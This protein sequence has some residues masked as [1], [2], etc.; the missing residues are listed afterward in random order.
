MPRKSKIEAT[1]RAY[2]V[3]RRRDGLSHEAIAAELVQRGTPL[4]V[5]TVHKIAPGAPGQ[6]PTKS[7]KARAS[8][9]GRA[10]PA[11]AP[12]STPAVELPPDDADV[13]TL[14]GWIASTQKLA[15]DAAKVGN[16]T[17]FASLQRLLQ[18]ALEKRRKIR[19]P[20]PP[21][22]DANPDLVQAGRRAADELHKL[23]DDALKG[24]AIAVKPA[25][26]VA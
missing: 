3:Q 20:A 13:A 11:A 8:A 2:V 9:A 18:S 21:D 19:P 4:S 15:D 1:T 25:T 24:P 16:L 26:A 10:A 23:I 12:P 6:A 22:P 14:D 7:T 17:G 5:G